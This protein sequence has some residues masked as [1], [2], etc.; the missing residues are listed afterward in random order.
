MHEKQCDV[1]PW[2]RQERC[3]SRF[4]L[5]EWHLQAT[6]K[7]GYTVKVYFWKLLVVFVTYFCSSSTVLQD[8]KKIWDKVL[9]GLSIPFEGNKRNPAKAAG[10][11]IYSSMFP[12]H[13]VLTFHR[14]LHLLAMSRSSWWSVT[15]YC[16]LNNPSA[17]KLAGMMLRCVWPRDAR[18]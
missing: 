8:K 15:K 12:P 5:V 18:C 1:T 10:C 7:H 2:A 11:S 3:G 9:F 17:L 16:C 6:C 14:N 4:L 13:S